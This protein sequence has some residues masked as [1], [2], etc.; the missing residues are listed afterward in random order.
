MIWLF[1]NLSKSFSEPKNKER[2]ES[3]NRLM[4]LFLPNLSINNLTSVYANKENHISVFVV[5]MTPINIPNLA[6]E[7]DKWLGN[8][9]M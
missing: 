7:G 1:D 4:S 2:E 3:S 6:Y 5:G 8:L 9:T